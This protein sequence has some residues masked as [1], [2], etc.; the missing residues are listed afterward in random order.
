MLVITEIPEMLYKGNGLFLESHLKE[1]IDCHNNLNYSGKT[2]ALW[3]YINEIL[4]CNM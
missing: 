1:H 3:R 2:L 4:L